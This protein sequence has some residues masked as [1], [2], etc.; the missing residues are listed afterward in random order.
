MKLKMFVKILVCLIL[1]SVAGA[2]HGQNMLVN[3]NLDST[4]ADVYFDGFDPT[5]ADDVPGWTLFL[6]AADGS[7]VLVNSSP[8]PFDVDMGIGPAGGGLMTAPGS[9]PAVVSG[10]G[11]TASLTYDNYFAATTT[12][13]FIDWFDGG[14]A[15]LSSSGGLLGDPNGA[16]TYDP[17]GQS[18]S[19][20]GTA[21]LG[22]ATAGVRFSSGDFLYGGLAA[23]NFSLVPEPGSLVLLAL[24]TAVICGSVRRTAR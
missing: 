6:G 23:D 13:Y 14:G 7:Y 19:V 18:F 5:L 9:R 12:S 11:Y 2:T 24:A 1:V 3:G 16:A 20:A 10:A 4:P 22:A 15:L 21:P 8:T 17:Y